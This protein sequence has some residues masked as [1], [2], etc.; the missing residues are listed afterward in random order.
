MVVVSSCAVH[1][2]VCVRESFLRC[3]VL[4]WF[5]VLM[6]VSRRFEWLAAITTLSLIGFG[7]VQILLGAIV[8][9]SVVLTANGIDC[10]GDGFVSAIVWIGLVF[11][12]KP[13][14]ARFNFGYYKFENLA[15]LTAAIV[16]FI[17]ATYIIVQSYYHLITPT[18]V[19]APLLGAVVAGIS[20]VVAL[21]LGVYKIYHGQSSRLSSARLDAFNT[22]KDGTTSTLTVL[23]LVLVS[24]GYNFDPYVGF[25]LAGI[26]YTVGIAAIK[27]SGFILLDACD[28]ECRDL[29]M[30][31]RGIAMSIPG[32][33]SAR[34]SRFR[35]TGPVF[36]GEVEITVSNKMTIDEFTRISSEISSRAKSEM[37]EIEHLAIVAKSQDENAGKLH[38]SG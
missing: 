17:L 29:G 10:I 15:S 9:Q 20:A 36:F 12:K 25:I 4:S 18:P 24:F 7:V 31:L 23:T 3:L 22:L 33:R 6:E 2:K 37:P 32:V 19:E 38:G 27:E 26:I 5:L 11:V 16:M 8:S 13:A 28:G 1:I 21:G 35:R 30:I 34:V 14:N